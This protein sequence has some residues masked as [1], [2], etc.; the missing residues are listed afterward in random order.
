MPKIRI[1]HIITRVDKGGSA[2]D[3]LLSVSRLNKEK[4]DVTLMSNN[5]SDSDKEIAEFIKQEKI[6]H[7]LIPEL[8]REIH[9]FKDIKAFYRIYQFINKEKFDI[10]HTHSSKAGILGRWAAKLAGTKFVVHTPHGHIFYG[11]FAWFKTKIFIYLEKLASLVT[12]RIITLTQRGKEE[13]LNYKIAKPNK[14]V[15]IY[16]GIEMEK[17]TNFQIDILKEKERLNIPLEAPVIGTVS[18]LETVK[19]NRYFIA[20]LPEIIKIF[21]ALKVFIIGDGSERG[22]L[23]NNV[24]KIG[25]LG[26]AVFMGQRKNIR[27]IVSIF[28]IFVLPSL[29]E[30]MGKCLLEAQALGVPIVATKVG[31]IPEVVKDGI[32][33]ILVPPRNPKAMAE[34]IINLLKDK[35]LRENMSKEAKKWIDN[36]FSAEAMVNRISNL[37]EE[38]TR[39]EAI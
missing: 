3:T 9:P 26:N 36:R 23:E 33:G 5:I 24:K 17:F 14:F 15:P 1:L 20:S 35:C 4:F 11:Y 37:Y 6:N 34:A 10:V 2:G 27:D 28:D 7:I 8:V 22:K 30:G 32:T 16:S 13:H 29:N 38:L 31:G 18:R 19:G 25:L 21:P 12:D 39:S